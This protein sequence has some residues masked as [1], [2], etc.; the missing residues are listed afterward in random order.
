MVISDEQIDYIKPMDPDVLVAMSQP[1][2]DRYIDEMDKERA[3]V[4]VD[5]AW[6][7]SSPRVLP[8][9]ILYR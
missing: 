6:C 2:L 8:I 4:L 9:C 7:R 3:A 1:A 5:T